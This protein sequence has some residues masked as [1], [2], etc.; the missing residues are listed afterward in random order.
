M[1]ALVVGPPPGAMIDG[2]KVIRPLGDGGFGLVYLVEKHG[3][4]YALK[5]ARHREASGDDK[6]NAP[7]ARCASWK[8]CC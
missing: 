6:R 7:R 4:L 1:T 8:S 2:F 5:L 3:K